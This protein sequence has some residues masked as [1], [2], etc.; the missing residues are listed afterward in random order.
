MAKKSIK[1]IVT[2]NKGVIV[3]QYNDGTIE[4]RKGD[5]NW[6]NNNPGNIEYGDFAKKMG[7]I[8]SDG[9]F[10]VFPTYEQGRK[11]KENLLFQSKR[12]QDKSIEEALNIYAPSSEN[13]TKKYIENVVKYLGVSATTP[14]S[15]L[16]K[17]QRDKFLDAI[18]K[19]EGFRQG[20]V[21]L[22]SSP[23][24]P[25][26]EAVE[27]IIPSAA[28]AELGTGVIPGGGEGTGLKSPFSADQWKPEPM[29]PE[30]RTDTV[31]PEWSA[32]MP[33][34]N[35][36]S[37]KEKPIEITEPIQVVPNVQREYVPE[38][39]LG[40]GAGRGFVNPPTVEPDTPQSMFR[41][42]EIEKMFM[43]EP[44]APENIWRDSSGNPILDRFGGY[45]YR[46]QY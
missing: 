43:G 27:A 13:D 20:S 5:R 34:T 26:A 3:V 40:A 11:A 23:K 12:Y 33:P 30:I 45:I 6:R 8:G 29:E 28:A 37:Y 22:I 46:K 1:K 42:S 35:Y 10:A 15:F 41:R 44:V 36:S 16:S 32:Y 31:D 21:K 4:E 2:T 7:A 9:R 25:V 38:V 24:S 14:L 18:Q 19:Q 17:K 39:Y